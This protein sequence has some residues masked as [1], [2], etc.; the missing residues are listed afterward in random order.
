LLSLV[1]KKIGEA[2]A[3]AGIDPALGVAT[4]SSRPDLSDLQCNGALAAARTL[5]RR[6]LDIAND[7]R[8]P[9]ESTGIF[10][11][12]SVA[13]PGFVNLRLADAFVLETLRAGA[14]APQ[15]PA[16]AL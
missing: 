14:V 16:R 5:K 15:A 4:E 8:G 12:V 3:A 9:L 11:H 6:P 1:N 13:G 10:S 2:F 7:L